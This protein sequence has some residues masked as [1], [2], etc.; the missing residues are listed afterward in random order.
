MVQNVA[1]FY[2][3]LYVVY[4]ISNILPLKNKLTVTIKEQILIYWLKSTVYS[5]NTKF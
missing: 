4:P 5:R 2:P 3:A 1:I